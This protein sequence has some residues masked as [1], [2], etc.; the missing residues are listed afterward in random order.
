MKQILHVI[1]W[2][3]MHAESMRTAFDQIDDTVRADTILIVTV[4]DGDDGFLY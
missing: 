4:T 3:P 1:A 2:G